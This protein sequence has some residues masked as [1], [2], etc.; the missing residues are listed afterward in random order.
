MNLENI[1]FQIRKL[2]LDE[3]ADLSKE[4]LKLD[5]ENIYA[6]LKDQSY[7]FFY[8]SMAMARLKKDYEDLVVDLNQLKFK[9]RKEVEEATP[10]KKL[11]EKYL[12]SFVEAHPDVVKL[13]KKINEYDSQLEIFKGLVK[14]LEQ[15][16]DMIVQMSSNRR[17]ETKLQ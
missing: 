12:E 7:T 5:L 6:N 13:Y 11:T 8:F 10:Q 17:A 4:L 15:R 16:R 9:V 1:I 2:N 14:A 3:I